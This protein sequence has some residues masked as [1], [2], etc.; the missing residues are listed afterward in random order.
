MD[1]HLKIPSNRVLW[2]LLPYLSIDELSLSEFIGRIVVHSYMNSSSFN[3]LDTNLVW[4][5]IWI[6]ENQLVCC[7]N[8]ARNRFFPSEKEKTD[9]PLEEI[10]IICP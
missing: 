10:L 5:I 9:L 8:S 1:A 6:R 3:D 2:P 7:Q 4:S